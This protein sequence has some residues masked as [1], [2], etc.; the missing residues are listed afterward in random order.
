MP[1][2]GIGIPRGQDKAGSGFTNPVKS[3]FDNKEWS[4][5]KIPSGNATNGTARMAIAQPLDAKA[6]EV[7]DFNVPEAGKTGPIAWQ[8]RNP[9]VP[10]V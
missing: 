1:N 3:K 10:R 4:R 9:V 5:V 8:M 7:L 6:I 2:G